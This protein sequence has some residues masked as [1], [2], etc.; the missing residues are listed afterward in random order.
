MPSG[1]VQ[2]EPRQP[3]GARG[4]IG[5]LWVSWADEFVAVVCCINCSSSIHLLLVTAAMFLLLLVAGGSDA[6]ALLLLSAFSCTI[7]E[8]TMVVFCSHSLCQRGARFKHVLCCL[9]GL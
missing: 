8:A 5:R 1:A 4:Q 9:A 6:V 2:D 3:S 7:R